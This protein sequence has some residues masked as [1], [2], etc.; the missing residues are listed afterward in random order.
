MLDQNQKT[1]YLNLSGLETQGVDV[2]SN[3]GFLPC[4][5]KREAV[6]CKRGTQP[7]TRLAVLGT[8][9]LSTQ[10]GPAHRGFQ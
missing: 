2:G 7:S 8:K 4:I 10:G 9:F 1:R 3:P 6:F 5:T